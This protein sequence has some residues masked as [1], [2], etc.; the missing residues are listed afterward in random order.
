MKQKLIETAIANWFA[1]YRKDVV[2]SLTGTMA[3]KIAVQVQNEFKEENNSD[4]LSETD[5]E[6]KYTVY[7]FLHLN[8]PI[9]IGNIILKNLENYTDSREL[10][11]EW[12][13]D[14]TL[15]REIIEI[16]ILLVEQDIPQAYLYAEEESFKYDNEINNA[17]TNIIQN[18]IAE[19]W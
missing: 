13:N 12:K 3:M 4:L 9:E 15:N 7:G 6:I 19:E 1:D 10:I 17:V 11:S 8:Y 18:Y 5:S 2:D 14:E 16:N